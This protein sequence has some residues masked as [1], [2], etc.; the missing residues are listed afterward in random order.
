MLGKIGLFWLDISRHKLYE[1]RSRENLYSAAV[2]I[3]VV[4]GCAIS[5]R[6]PSLLRVA[7]ET[8]PNA[9]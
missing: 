1:E 4:I 2:R 5:A 7:D 6:Y 9:P 8:E 3:G